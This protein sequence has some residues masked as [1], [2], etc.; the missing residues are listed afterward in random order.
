MI[1]H[2]TEVDLDS[3]GDGITDSNE[4]DVYGTNPNNADTDGDGLNDY[5]EIFTTGTN[6]TDADTDDD[7]LNDGV[8]VNI[9]NTDPFNND[10]DGDGLI[11]GLEVLT[12][13]TDPLVADPDADAD[14]YYWFEDCNDSNDQVYPYALEILNGIDDDCDNLWDEGFNATDGDEDLSLIH[15]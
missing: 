2:G 7:F 9:N 1:I 3:D 6:A 11:D 12:Y 15:I 4:T 8:E 13:F 10:T 14:S 5:V